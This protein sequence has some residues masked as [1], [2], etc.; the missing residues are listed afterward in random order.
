MVIDARIG[1][2]LRASHVKPNKNE[3]KNI[4]R[5]DNVYDINNVLLLKNIDGVLVKCDGIIR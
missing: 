1:D 4:I 3:I 5:K 2:T